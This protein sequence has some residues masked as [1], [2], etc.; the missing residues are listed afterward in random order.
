MNS[1]T[2]V[3]HP[4]ALG[5]VVLV[6]HLLGSVEGH[7]TLAAGLEKSQLLAGLGRVSDCLDFATLPMHELFTPGQP[8]APGDLPRRL[9]RCDRLISFFG[10]PGSPEADRLSAVTA[11][12]EA[13]FLPVRPPDDWPEHLL[14]LWTDRL[15]LPRVDAKPPAWPVPPAWRA[16]AGQWLQSQGLP[17][18][19]A[20]GVLHPGSGSPRKNWPAERFA[21]LG[22]A[23][24]STAGLRV[25]WVLG[26]VEMERQPGLAKQ[27]GGAVLSCPPL[28]LLAGLLS[29][30]RLY[31]GNDSGVTHLAAAAGAPTLA[32]FEPSGVRH[33]APRG[34]AV[35]VLSAQRMDR[36]SLARVLAAA[37]GSAQPGRQG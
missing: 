36:L 5:D 29:R 1:R 15:R 12:R 33:F 23:L 18:D 22:E 2:L 20:M 37:E 24:A 16:Q 25:V 14:D 31:V 11:A 28:A 3:I 17:E 34:P 32:L 4:G 19:S 6:G 7:K 26:P 10:N 27:L 30:A 35:R 8:E 21:K 9:G 13:H